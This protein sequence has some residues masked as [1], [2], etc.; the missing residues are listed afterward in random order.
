MKTLLIISKYLTN[1]HE[2]IASR[3]LTPSDV[4]EICQIIKENKSGLIDD[5][6]SLQ[7]RPVLSD[8]NQPLYCEARAYWDEFEEEEPSLGG[9]FPLKMSLFE[10]RDNV[11]VSRECIVFYRNNE[12]YNILVTHPADIFYGGDGFSSSDIERIVDRGFSKKTAAFL[13]VVEK[14]LEES[15]SLSEEHFVDLFSLVIFYLLEDG[16][17]DEVKKGLEELLSKYDNHRELLLGLISMI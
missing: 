10:T 11:D 4:E 15:I 17:S 3:R 2:L 7:F 6:L 8:E 12:D 5:R 16:K 14:Y 13:H 1:N 9:V